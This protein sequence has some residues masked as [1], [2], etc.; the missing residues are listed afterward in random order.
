M[1]LHGGMRKDDYLFM[2]FDL[3]LLLA[4]VIVEEGTVVLVIGGGGREHALCYALKRSPSCVSVFCAPGNAGISNSGDAIC[5]KDL[6]ISDSSAVVAF[7]RERSIGL[8][9]VGPE[10]P[11][12]AG[13]ANDLIKAG[14]PTFG[15]SSEAAALEGSKD[16]MKR[17]CV[18]YDIPTAKV[19][20]DLDLVTR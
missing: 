14:I 2:L 17:L 4:I 6:D 5:I 7:C 8:V 12:V 10:A 15:P 11:L 13:L 19:H 3:F 9:V 1:F 18:K 16:F 20:C